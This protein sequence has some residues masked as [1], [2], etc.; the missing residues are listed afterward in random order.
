MPKTMCAWFRAVAAT[1]VL[2]GCAPSPSSTVAPVA[3]QA[4]EA[5]TDAAALEKKLAAVVADTLAPGAVV[6]VRSAKHGDFTHAFGT[7]AIG[8]RE[9]IETTDQVRIG[10]NTKTM[11]GTVILQLVDEGKLRL[12][13]PIAKLACG[14]R[15]PNG[16]K[17]TIEHLLTMRS[18]I[19]NY[20]LTMTLNRALDDE[21]LRAWTPAELVDLAL[22]QRT[23]FAPGGAFEYSNTN[24]VLLGLVIEEL[25]KMPVEEALRAR[26]FGPLGMKSTSMPARTS[27]AI[28]GAHPRGYQF[29]T[30]VETMTTGVFPPEK[31]AAA[32]AGRFLPL[33][34]T[35]VNPS[36]AW[37]AGSAI[38]S[39]DDLARYVEA[40]V[41]GSL[42][43]KEMQA[44]RLGSIRPRD[45]SDPSVGYG[46][47]IAKLGSYYGHTGELPGYNSIMA[48][49]PQQ[50]ITIV[51]WTSLAAAPDGRAPAI[52][53]AKTVMKELSGR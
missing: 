10:S 14:K 6:V 32:R 37:T 1:V 41:E 8:S 7:R 15:I 33:D 53:M 51:A 3:P 36:W 4:A 17:I 46:W 27:A 19:P 31:Q 30:N 26:I 50:K 43:S 47:A 22:G 29:G 39:A 52:E 20:S 13:D 34:A 23:T 5:P 42:V 9:P 35:D 16:D 40:M 48:Y 12:D 45:A 24:T 2:G 18:G 49:D 21:P 28:P 11:T 25:T 38:S 44:K